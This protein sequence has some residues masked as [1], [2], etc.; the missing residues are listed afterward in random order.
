MYKRG[1]KT[2]YIGNDVGMYQ[3]YINGGVELI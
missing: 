2:K 3:G 1:L